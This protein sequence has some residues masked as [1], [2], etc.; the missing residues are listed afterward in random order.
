MK[1]LERFKDGWKMVLKNKV[2]SLHPPDQ[3]IEIKF[4][5]KIDDKIF[6]ITIDGGLPVE[7]K[8]R[9]SKWTL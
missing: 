5:V 8:K 7:I 6:S 1:T 3:D 9:T 4:A 2:V